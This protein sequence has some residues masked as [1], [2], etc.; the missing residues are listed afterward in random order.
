KALSSQPHPTAAATVQWPRLDAAVS[1]RLAQIADPR[2]RDTVVICDLLRPIL[3][4]QAGPHVQDPHELM[5]ERLEKWLL[6]KSIAAVFA[7]HYQSDY[8]GYVTSLLV[9]TLLTADNPLLAEE[10]HLAAIFADSHGAEFLQVNR[11][12]D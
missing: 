4:W 5:R 9:A 11:H 6:R 3:D 2:A 7:E 12:N 10:F 1:R 8:E